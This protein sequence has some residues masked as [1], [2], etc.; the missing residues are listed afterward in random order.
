MKFRIPLLAGLVA[1]FL[2]A[3][4]A[5]ADSHVSTTSSAT[6][7][8]EKG[9]GEEGPKVGNGHVRHHG[10]KRWKERINTV[11]RKPLRHDIEYTDSRDRDEWQGQTTWQGVRDRRPMVARKTMGFHDPR[12]HRP[13][14]ERVLLV[15]RGPIRGPGFEE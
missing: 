6:A 8:A 5:A 12:P 4:A 14:A 15:S 2:V 10:E 1:A 11:A 7:T 9:Q 13:R 3:G